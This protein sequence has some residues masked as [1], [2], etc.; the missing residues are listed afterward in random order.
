MLR[1]ASEPDLA[2]MIRD[3]PGPL[4]IQGN[5]TKSGMLRP[6]QAAGTLSTSAF[7]GI[8]L[9]AS[10]ELVMRAWA[11]T[12]LAEIELVLAENGQQLIAEPSHFFGAEQTLG[13]IVATNLSGPRRV[14]GGA[15]RDHVLGVRAVNGKGELL[16]FGGR[17]HKNVTGLDIAKLLAGS[18]GT[19]AV[20]TEITFKVQPVSE[21]IGTIMVPEVDAEAAVRVMRAGL[22][23]PFSVTGAAYLPAGR[24][25]LLRI[26][27]F[28]PSVRYRCAKLARQFPG[29]EILDMAAS[30]AL[31]R[32]IR[33][34]KFLPPGEAVWRV[35]IRPSAAPG[36]LRAMEAIGVAGFLDWGGG[37]AWLSG[38]AT[39]EIHAAVCAAA[40]TA[41]GVWWLVHAPEPLR[42]AVDV[43]PPEPP[44]LARLRQRVQH[45]FDPRGILNPLKLGAA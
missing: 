17:V 6:V 19:L 9:Y 24:R 22:G 40:G 34:A 20:M 4:L 31:W 10:N 1:P 14:S 26:E 25:A 11:G 36:L 45:G 7:S 44:A 30:I 28:E 15:T 33:D 13:G 18:F 29:A 2:M 3:A 8:T 12:P 35:S 39:P 27:A 42:A 38:P 43:L 5:G 23:S 21:S 41:G 16:Q 37:L 32:D